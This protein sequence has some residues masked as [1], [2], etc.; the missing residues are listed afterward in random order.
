MDRLKL[1]RT[2]ILRLLLPVPLRNTLLASDFDGTLAP[3]VADPAKAAVM[4]E[5][6]AALG[7]LVDRGLRVIVLSGRSTAF[8]QDRVPIP[9]V[10]MLGDYG[11]EEPSTLEARAL[12][13]FNS[14]AGAIIA[15]QAGI[16]LEVKPGSSS[17][18][19][20]AAPEAADELLDE[21]A[22]LASE[23]GLVASRG[24][25]VV[26][27]RPARASKARAL[28]SLVREEQPSGVLFAGDDEGD[29][30]VFEAMTCINI[31]H[32]AIGVRSKEA[33]PAL[34]EHCDLIVEGPPGFASF[35]TAWLN[36]VQRREE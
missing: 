4:P 22:P 1:D 26:E 15:N 6:L 25:M 21:L 2:R 23:L 19:F 28:E 11:L 10:R 32:L 36:L 27:V 3:I 14:R 35:L 24:R 7:A 9:G 8:L 5:A 34:F 16:L 30:E 31:R 20:R 13:R 33:P 29:R 17:V 18:H 12:E